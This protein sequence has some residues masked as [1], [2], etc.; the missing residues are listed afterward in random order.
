MIRCLLGGINCHCWEPISNA[1]AKGVPLFGCPCSFF[2]YRWIRLSL[3]FPCM[4]RDKSRGRHTRKRRVHARQYPRGRQ[5]PP[6]RGMKHSRKG[7]GSAGSGRFLFQISCREYKW[8]CFF[9][10]RTLVSRVMPNFWATLD[11]LRLSGETSETNRSIPSSVF[12][13]SDTPFAA[14][15]A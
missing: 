9:Q 11:D 8:Y 5:A 1:G 13:C 15:V 3:S 7:S 12:P 10:R 6:L 4:R 14:S 2:G